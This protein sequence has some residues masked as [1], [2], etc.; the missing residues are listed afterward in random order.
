MS[1]SWQTPARTVWQV[2]RGPADRSYADMLM[3]HGVALIGPGDTGPWRPDH[4]AFRQVRDYVEKLVLPADSVV[5]DGIRCGLY[6]REAGLEP[7]A[8]A[9]LVRLKTA[10]L[11]LFDRLR[12]V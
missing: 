9:N 10:V 1:V 7:R 6:G 3:E 4:G 11:G 8:Y 5:T 12:R 2:G